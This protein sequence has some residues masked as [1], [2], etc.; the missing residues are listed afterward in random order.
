MTAQDTYTTCSRWRWLLPVTACMLCN[1]W[2]VFKEPSLSK[3]RQAAVEVL[4][5]ECVQCAI[6][7]NAQFTFSS[8]YCSPPLS[9]ASFISS[10]KLKNALSSADQQPCSLWRVWAVS[11]FSILENVH[12]LEVICWKHILRRLFQPVL[13][14]CSQALKCLLSN[15]AWN[16]VFFC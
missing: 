14:H 3:L 2:E 4:Q 13:L 16:L 5:D 9:T 10:V 12:F 1:T 6:F 15:T 7:G 11:V 8:T